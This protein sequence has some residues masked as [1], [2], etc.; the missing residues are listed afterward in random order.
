MDFKLDHD[1]HIHS[2]LSLCSNDKEQNKERLLKYAEENGFGTICV[3]DHYWDSAVAGASD[4]YAVQDFEHISQIKPL[5]QSDKVR[6]LFGCETEMDMNCSLGIP[7]ERFDEFDFIIIPTTHMHMNGLVVSG[8]EDAAERAALWIKRFDALLDMDLPFEKVGIAHLTCSLIY[9]KT[10]ESYREVLR[11]I[12]D[13]EYSRLFKKAAQKGVGTELNF[14]SLALEGE[15]LEEE[16]R[17]FRIAK[18]EGCKFYFGSDRHHPA[19]LETSK[20]NFAK[21]AKC[22]ELCEEDKFVI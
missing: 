14:N 2:F 10:K 8:E 22:L 1:L 7:K 19:E 21:I 15:E 12:P 5:P 17:P 6:F 3:T 4:W 18:A 20:K 16:L 9:A 11:L 13:S